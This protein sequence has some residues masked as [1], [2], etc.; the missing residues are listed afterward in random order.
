MKKKRKIILYNYRFP[1]TYKQTNTDVTVSTA[2]M[3]SGHACSVT[4]VHLTV[5][6]LRLNY[7]WLWEPE[8]L[9]GQL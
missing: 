4:F 3:Q 8:L 9:K 6:I 7:L 5:C 1:F 2:S